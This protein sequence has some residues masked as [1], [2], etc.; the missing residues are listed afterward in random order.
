MVNTSQSGQLEILS[1][2]FSGGLINLVRFEIYNEKKKKKTI[3]TLPR[4]LIRWLLMFF[5]SSGHLL[6]CDLS[7]DLRCP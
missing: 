6:Q 4:I 1:G 7:S 2:C 3:S 5:M